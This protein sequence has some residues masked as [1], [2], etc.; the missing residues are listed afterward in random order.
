MPVLQAVSLEKFGGRNAEEIQDH[1]WVKHQRIS[2]KA[3]QTE[4]PVA[5]QK[6]MGNLK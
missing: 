3:V 1:P 5:Q 6:N 2:Q 4:G